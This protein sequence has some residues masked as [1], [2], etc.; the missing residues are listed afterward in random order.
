[1]IIP[2]HGLGS[3][4]DCGDESAER[5]D[6]SVPMNEGE[7][8]VNVFQSLILIFNFTSQLTTPYHGLGSSTDCGDESAETE[9]MPDSFAEGDHNTFC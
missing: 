8:L 3:S 7:I 5:E 4:T 9:E 2:Y 1:M 6:I